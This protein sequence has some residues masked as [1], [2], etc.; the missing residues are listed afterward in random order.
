MPSFTEE[1]YLKAIYHLSLNGKKDVSTNELS[2][3]FGTKA[4]SVTD[5]LKKLSQKEFINYQ[6]YQGVS[7]TN[8]GYL[9]AVNILRRHRIW[10]TFLVNVLGYKWDEVHE[11]AEELE[12]INDNS[13]IDRIHNH[14]GNPKF[15]PH[16]DP[17]PDSEGNIFSISDLYLSNLKKG[18]EAE[19][20]GVKNSSSS[21]LQ[22]LDK[23]K[24]GLGTKL[25]VQ[26][27]HDFDNS[28]QIL[29]NKDKQHSLSK[30]VCNNLRIA[31][32]PKIK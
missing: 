4:S 16:G 6:K 7:L 15:D 11:L 14:L 28:M 32:L 17:I 5:M 23:F 2:A 25:K 13:L 1:N 12:H 30:Q 10:E 21:F 27:I 3:Y 8:E 9:A 18:D 31:K 26:E 22:Y 20:I 29:V 19:I 24:I